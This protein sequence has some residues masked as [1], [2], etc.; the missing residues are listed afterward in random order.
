[1]RPPEVLAA[2]ADRRAPR[3]PRSSQTGSCAAADAADAAAVPAMHSARSN[4]AG[5]G[6]HAGDVGEGRAE[7]SARAGR[8]AAP[9]PESRACTIRGAARWKELAGVAVAGCRP[10]R[11]A[12]DTSGCSPTLSATRR[13]SRRR[14]CSMTRRRSRG[15]PTATSWSRSREQDP[16]GR[17]PA[18]GCWRASAHSGRLGA[19]KRWRG[20][21]TA[22]ARSTG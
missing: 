22:A 14:W 18:A 3:F 17:R 6:E 21:P 20:D 12:A 9:C 13:P 2:L 10:C 16:R 5:A 11:G 8:S 1:M 15:G 19:R 7:S 4:A